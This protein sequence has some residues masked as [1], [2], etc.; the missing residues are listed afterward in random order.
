VKVV[1]TGLL[2]WAKVT[3]S[4]QFLGTGMIGEGRT[5][6][7]DEILRD[8]SG[9]QRLVKRLGAKGDAGGKDARIGRGAYTIP[10]TN[11]FEHKCQKKNRNKARSRLSECTESYKKKKFADRQTKSGI[12]RQQCPAVTQHPIRREKD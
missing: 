3:G 12:Q 11:R 1:V 5:R 10:R 2:K 6:P 7:L 8:S 4:K 9:F